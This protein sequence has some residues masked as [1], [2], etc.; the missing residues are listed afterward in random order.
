MGASGDYFDVVDRIIAMDQYHPVHVTK[1]AKMIVG[2]S[3][4]KR[5][6]EGGSNFGNLPNRPPLG[7]SFDA[8]RESGK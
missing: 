4:K 8:S 2:M 6:A 1:A 7:D 3:P 5:L